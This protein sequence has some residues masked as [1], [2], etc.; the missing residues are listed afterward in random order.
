[1]DGT[2]KTGHMVKA[3]ELLCCTKADTQYHDIVLKKDSTE[4]VFL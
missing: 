4:Y 2:L 1:M 3:M